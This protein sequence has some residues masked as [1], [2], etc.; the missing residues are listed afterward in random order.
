MTAATF[1][2]TARAHPSRVLGEWL[3]GRD[4]GL[5]RAGFTPSNAA[6]QLVS[7][8]DR[9]A[10]LELFRPTVSPSGFY[11]TDHTA[12]LVSTVYACLTKIAG[13]VAQLPV[14]HYRLDADGGRQRVQGSPIWWL[15]NESPTAAWTAA[16]WKEWIVRCVHLRGDQYTEILRDP[17]PRAAGAPI[18]LRPWHPDHC[19]PEVVLDPVTGQPRLRYDVQDPLTGRAR[20]IDQDDMLHFSGF[21]FDGR[22][23]LSAVQHA[24]RTGIGNALAAADYTG[25]TIGEGALPKVVIETA[26][27]LDKDQ[28][29]DLAASFVA[30]YAGPGSQRLPLILPQGASLKP[31]SISPVDME[32]LASRRF[33]R[34]DICQ[35]FGVPPVLIGENQ[36]T[37][38]WGTG[39]EQITIGFVRFTIKAHLSRWNEELNR[40]LFRRAG[41]FVEFE[42]DGLLS[43]DSKAQSEAFKAALGGPGSGDGY[44]SVDEVRK[45]KNLPLLGGEYARPFRAQRGPAKP[46]GDTGKKADEA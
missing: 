43:G 40:K 46:A 30:R 39:V 6:T 4:G 29:G 16:S 38:S 31:L 25:R 26:S 3:S 18:G 33:E 32:L 15:L 11:V 28:K 36:A 2:L 19:R 17:S 5:A 20:G 37:S 42:L 9:E 41:Q 7:S 8:G 22:K 27:K 35:A 24:A 1:D 10:M 44:M 23:S 45:L 21:G 34:E 12:M 13:A 14:H